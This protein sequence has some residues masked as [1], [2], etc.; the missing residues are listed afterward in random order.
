MILPSFI[1]SIFL[2]K[3]K[4]ALPPFSI[5]VFSPFSPFCSFPVSFEFWFRIQFRIQFWIQFRIRFQILFYMRIYSDFF[6]GFEI[7]KFP[8]AFRS[9]FFDV[10]LCIKNL[11]IS[12]FPYLNM[13]NKLQIHS[14]IHIANVTY[15]LYEFTQYLVFP[16]VE[17]ANGFKYK[18]T[19]T[20]KVCMSMHYARIL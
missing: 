5:C 18:G 9:T 6:T 7:K 10:S 14:F 11:L 3:K 15:F 20:F 1:W 13:V 19:N 4:R 17:L 16:F 2:M 12:I 8:C